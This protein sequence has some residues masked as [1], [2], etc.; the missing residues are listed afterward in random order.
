MAVWEPTGFPF[1]DKKGVP[2]DSVAPQFYRSTSRHK[3]DVK[4]VFPVKFVHVDGQAFLDHFPYMK[5]EAAVHGAAALQAIESTHQIL[6]ELIFLTIFYV[7]QPTAVERNL[8]RRTYAF[9]NIITTLADNNVFFRHK[10]SSYNVVY[11]HLYL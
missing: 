7:G 6:P 3:F 1:C 10:Q 9:K 2:L 5:S 11:A 4:I 8:A